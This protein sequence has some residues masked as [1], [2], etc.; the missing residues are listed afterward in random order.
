MLR[1][2]A[3]TLRSGSSRCDEGAHVGAAACPASAKTVRVDV[4]SMAATPDMAV[5]RRRRRWRSIALASILRGQS[6]NLYGSNGETRKRSMAL[7]NEIP[8]FDHFNRDVIPIRAFN[9]DMIAV[10]TATQFGTTVYPWRLRKQ[11]CHV[12]IPDCCP[13]FARP[14]DRAG[15]RAGCPAQQRMLGDVRGTALRHA[16]QPSPGRRQGGRGRD[17]LCRPFD[18]LHRHAWRCADRNRL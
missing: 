18:L 16:R 6:S 15:G 2:P 1:T 9:A 13:W 3:S 5:P 7:Y 4:N 8:E 10:M 12:A 17:H 11:A 14:N